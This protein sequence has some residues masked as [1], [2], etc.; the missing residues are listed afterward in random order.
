MTQDVT[1]VTRQALYEQ[2][3]SMPMTKLAKE[4]GVSDVALRKAC[5]KANIPL[6]VQG[7]WNKPPTVR[8]KARRPSLPADGGER[9]YYISTTRFPPARPAEKSHPAIGACA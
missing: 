1:T 9:P 3:W 2:V 5:R 8:T 6:P 7:H 4:Y